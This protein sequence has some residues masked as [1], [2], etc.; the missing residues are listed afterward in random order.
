[1]HAPP[2]IDAQPL[3]HITWL[4]RESLH[5]NWYNPNH[6]APQEMKLLKQSLLEQGWLHPILVTPDS[7]IIDGF[8]RWTI[9]ADPLI[10]RL[11]DGRVPVL[12]LPLASLDE[13]MIV[14]VR[15][16][17]SKGSHGVLKMADLVR[18]ILE[19]GTL[20]PQELQQRL[21]MEYEEVQ[22]LADRGGIAR[23]VG[24]QTFSSGWIPE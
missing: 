10:A 11:T 16:N 3:S 13:Q 17:R 19:R 7:E 15:I 8:H 20:S 2:G 22:R 12:I 4:P 9:S 5:A 21:G 18:A 24:K 6:V 1:M 23:R 14:T